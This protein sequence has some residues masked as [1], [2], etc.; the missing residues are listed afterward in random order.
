LPISAATVATPV[1][2]Q[3][4]TNIP[5]N[6]KPLDS[7]DYG[8][9]EELII[10]S[11]AE[12]SAEL[13]DS[14]GY[15][16]DS[17]MLIWVDTAPRGPDRHASL[18]FT[19]NV[20]A[21]YA[22]PIGLT[23]SFDMGGVDPTNYKLV[24]LTY[25]GIAF[26]T[27]AS[28]KQ[29][30]NNPTWAA[31]N[32]IPNAPLFQFLQNTVEGLDW[33]SL[34]KKPTNRA[35]GNGQ[36]RTGTRLNSNIPVPQVKE[37]AGHRYVVEDNYVEYLGWSFFM[38]HDAL[39]GLKVYDLR[40]M[41]ERIAYEV[42]IA[43]AAAIYSG[44]NDLI[45]ATT[46]YQDSAWGMGTCAAQ[47]V[48]G[49]D[50]PS[51]GTLL[52]LTFL[53]DSGTP[54]TLKNVICVYEMD[55]QVPLRKHWF[56]DYEGGYASYGGLPRSSL[57]VRMT[58]P[59]YNYD[60]IIDYVLYPNGAFEV[61]MVT[62]GYLQSSFTSPKLTSEEAMF[63]PKIMEFTAGTLHDHIFSVKLDLDILGKNNKLNKK[64][65]VAVSATPQD[66]NGVAYSKLSNFAVA[67]DFKTKKIVSSDITTE[68]GFTIV[69]SNPSFYTVNSAEKNKWGHPRG[70]KVAINGI[71]QNLVGD[72]KSNKAISYSKY[73]LVATRHHDNEP[74]I[75]SHYDQADTTGTVQLSGKPL[76]DAEQLIN[77]E[78]IDNQDLVIW[79]S[80]G[81][82]H[83]PHAEDIPVTHTVA[84]GRAI[85]IIPMNMF[86]YDDSMDLG[87]SVYADH[88]CDA[89]AKKAKAA[90][91]SY[92]YDLKNLPVD[93]CIMT[94]DPIGSNL[95]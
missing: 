34:R 85:S 66:I 88:S 77:G 52:D 43:E 6:S 76:V 56:T 69:P 95:Y 73:T 79:A 33:S 12:I 4:V 84:N 10:S 53:E 16:Y 47:M 80:V 90:A 71:V 30:Y 82:H 46:V 60:Y 36:V 48:L 51:T 92:A 81:L 29:A 22:N 61:R 64:E 59:V 28:F 74:S 58:L 68:G 63:S 49:I 75:A 94:Y 26:E 9:L 41:G 15:D 70:Y 72:T 57:V 78:S 5:Y 42:G 62:S 24:L 54:I 11:C 87:N 83:I 32:K 14:Y 44:I 23:M 8:Y 39:T 20:D 37:P 17:G 31:Q 67:D 55:E 13:I 35:R 2:Y 65:I 25:N 91:C 7:K 19:F 45:Q 27:T 50:C 18:F 40:Y 3:G 93:L 89:P 38:G 86:D 21:N 1:S